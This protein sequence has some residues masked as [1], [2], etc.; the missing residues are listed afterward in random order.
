MS[1]ADIEKLTRNIIAGLPGAEE[2]YTLEQFRARLAEYDQIDKAQLRENMAVFLRAI[3]PVCEEVGVRLAVHP[4]DP[5]R[6]S[7]A[8]RVSFRLSKTCSG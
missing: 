1:E 7:L 5:P 2:G 6:R 4:D 8:C 3:V